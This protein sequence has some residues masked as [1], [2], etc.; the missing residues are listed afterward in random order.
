MFKKEQDS[1]AEMLYG[2]S[3]YGESDKRELSKADLK[4]L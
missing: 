2:G 1:E 4:G 3:H